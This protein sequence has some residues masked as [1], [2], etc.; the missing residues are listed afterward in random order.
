MFFG[1]YTHS[2]A[3]GGR[4]TIPA[5]LRES[6]IQLQQGPR[7]FLTCGA[8]PCI[9]AY[10]QARISEILEGMKDGS[11]SREQA[12]EFKRIFGGEGGMEAWDK[13]GRITLPEGLKAYA[14]IDK[15]VT[16]VGAVD[17]IEIWDVKAYAER[18]KTARAV[19]DD[20]AGK[21]IP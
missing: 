16:I 11:I 5:K 3:D 2:L 20:I 7:L 14:E 21:V 6:A 4:L 9:V 19:Y 15:E 8:E 13:H 12:R 10:T 18:L 1:T 17:C